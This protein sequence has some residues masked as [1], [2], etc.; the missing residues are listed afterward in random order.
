MPQLQ[1]CPRQNNLPAAAV[2]AAACCPQVQTVSYF[3][4]KQQVTFIISVRRE[5]VALQA[6]RIWSRTV[7][8]LY[9][10]VVKAASLSVAVRMAIGTFL[11]AM[12]KLRFPLP[13]VGLLSCS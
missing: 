3:H 12:F 13:L 9:K 2:A 11:A 1:F 8:F 10:R 5:A 6:S 7:C 4:P